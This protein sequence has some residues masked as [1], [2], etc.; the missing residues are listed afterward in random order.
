MGRM[1]RMGRI[2]RGNEFLLTLPAQVYNYPLCLFLLD[3]TG[4]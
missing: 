3:T 4:S 1:G 2:G